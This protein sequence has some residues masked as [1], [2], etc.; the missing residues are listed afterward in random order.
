MFGDDEEEDLA[1]MVMVGSKRSRGALEGSMLA[2]AEYD[3]AELGRA[4]SLPSPFPFF[5][6]EESSEGLARLVSDD[7]IVGAEDF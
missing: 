1:M 3:Q 5:L 7:I 6:S 2:E 4:S